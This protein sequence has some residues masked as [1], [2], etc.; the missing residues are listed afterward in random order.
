MHQYLFI[1]Y[2][3]GH[4]TTYH[5]FIS[6]VELSNEQANKMQLAKHPEALRMG[7]G[8]NHILDIITDMGFI[9]DNYV[10][11]EYGVKVFK[12]CN[13]DLKQWRVI[14]GISGNY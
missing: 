9:V 12:V 6:D 8:I 5:P 1:D 10:H 11:P 7:T 2:N 4:Q 3:N 13:P 14:E